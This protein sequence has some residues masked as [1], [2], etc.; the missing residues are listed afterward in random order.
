VESGIAFAS[1]AHLAHGSARGLARDH[2][3]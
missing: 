2:D 3:R 1:I